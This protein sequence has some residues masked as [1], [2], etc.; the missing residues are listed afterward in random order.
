MKPF[1]NLLTAAILLTA[2]PAFAGSVAPVNLKDLSDKS[3]RIFHGTCIAKESI[4]VK[5]RS[6]KVD[7]P[8][9]RYTF[10]VTEA[11]KGGE[12][13]TFTVTQLDRFQDGRRFLITPELLNL[14]HYDIGGEYVLFMGRESYHTLSSPMGMPQGVFVVQQGKARNMASTQMVMTG[15]KEA[16]A[17]TSHASLFTPVAGKTTNLNRDGLDVK[18]LKSL[19]KDLIDGKVKAPGISEVLK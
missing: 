14:P 17:G 6:G 9:M 13:G 18:G 11:L 10:R 8:A 5:D 1:A 12:G 2:L 3:T 7:I 15:L 19:V 16:V 4:V